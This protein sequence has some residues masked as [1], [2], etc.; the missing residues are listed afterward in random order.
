MFVLNNFQI[1]TNMLRYTLGIIWMALLITKSE[2]QIA[3]IDL[4]DIALKHQSLFE[5]K[6]NIIS[7]KSYDQKLDSIIEF[8]FNE[9]TQKWDQPFCKQEFTYND[10]LEEVFWI[11]SSWDSSLTDWNQLMK[12]EMK[13]DQ[14]GNL[15]GFVTY[16]KGIDKQWKEFIKEDYRYDTKNKLKQTNRFSWKYSS[17]QWVETE[18]VKCSY[19]NEGKLLKDSLLQWSLQT[20]DWIKSS[21]NDYTYIPTGKQHY[22]YHSVYNQE[23]S[24][25]EEDEYTWYLYTYSYAQLISKTVFHKYDEEWKRHEMEAYSRGDRGEINGNKTVVWDYSEEQPNFDVMQSQFKYD[26]EMSSDEVLFPYYFRNPEALFY[27]HKIIHNNLYKKEEE[28]TD[29]VQYRHEDYFYST[30]GK[31]TGIIKELFNTIK[32]YPNP[33]SDFITIEGLEKNQQFYVE[34]YNVTGSKVLEKQINTT[35]ETLNVSFLRPGIYFYSVVMNNQKQSG[36]IIIK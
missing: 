8:N 29:M 34:L 30:L 33:A 3:D 15:A 35:I 14:E 4:K 10:K 19:D 7:S 5:N 12:D 36:K 31:S 27:H 9:T 22:I 13:Y 16:V 11:Y 21:K 26:Y 20:E 1:K 17:N 6:R 2:A 28:S 24:V 32:V 23:L 18:Q 25:W